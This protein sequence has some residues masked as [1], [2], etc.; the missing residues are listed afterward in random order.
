MKES[1]KFSLYGDLDGMTVR[2]LITML[3]EYSD[4]ARI[5]VRSETKYGFG[6]YT[7]AEDEFFVIVEETK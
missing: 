3:E 7:N 1:K 6:G 2:D 4:D 5:D